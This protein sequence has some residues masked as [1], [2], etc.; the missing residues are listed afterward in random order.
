MGMPVS[1]GAGRGQG[2]EGLVAFHQRIGAS[3]TS[4][5]FDID[6][7]VYKVNDRALQQRLGFC[8]ARASLGGGAQVSRR[9]SR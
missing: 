6:G 7:V 8:L 5:P 4:C 2:A 3:A 1:F 9:R